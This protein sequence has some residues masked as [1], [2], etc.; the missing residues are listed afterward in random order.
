MGKNDTRHG[1]D[2]PGALGNNLKEKDLTLQAAQYMYKRLKELGVPV[3][4]TR[5]TD[6]TL[7]RNERVS[8][9]LNA[10]GNNPNVIVVANHINAGGGEWLLPV[11]LMIGY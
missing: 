4:I 6:I 2:D 1:G 10:F 3:V 8:K 5:D 9:I 11:Q 7:D